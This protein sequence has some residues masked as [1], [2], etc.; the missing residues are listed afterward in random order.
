MVIG[1]SILDNIEW[2]FLVNPVYVD[3]QCF[4]RMQ[5]S[6]QNDKPQLIRLFITPLMMCVAAESVDYQVL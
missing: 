5:L 1:Q 2:C 3:L 4:S 6:H